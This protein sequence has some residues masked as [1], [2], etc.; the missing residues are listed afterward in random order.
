[1]G[2][3]RDCETLNFAKVRF[4]LYLIPHLV[5][6]R[7]VQTVCLLPHRGLVLAVPE[8][9]L[10]HPHQRRVQPQQLARAQWA[11]LQ[12]K[13]NS[14]LDKNVKHL[15]ICTVNKDLNINDQ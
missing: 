14:Y 2:L 13:W 15:F 5:L 11:R 1:M 4:Q 3:L 8:H 10:G 9:D 6:Q 7:E 12:C